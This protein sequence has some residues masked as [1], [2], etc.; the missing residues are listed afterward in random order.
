MYVEIISLTNEKVKKKRNH[1]KK[2]SLGKQ[3]YWTKLIILYSPLDEESVKM[4]KKRT[5]KQARTTM[6]LSFLVFFW[7]T[8]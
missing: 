4:K 3:K 2:D 1:K 5:L 7:D 6:V 8:I